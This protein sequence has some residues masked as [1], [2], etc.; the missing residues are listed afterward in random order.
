MLDLRETF[1]G[2]MGAFCCVY[3]GL[4]FEM[5][6]VRLQTQGS[7]NAYKSVI[8]AFRRIV[9]EE[10]VVALWKGAIPALSSSIIENSVLFSANGFAK[11]AAM[12]MYAKQYVEHEKE[13][14]LT[15][16]DEG[17]MGAFGGC[18]SATVLIR[19]FECLLLLL[20]V[21]QLLSHC[22]L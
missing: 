16:M 3:A 12:S 4:P 15:T 22:Q 10:G 7:R 17:C 20:L 18:F 11:R 9:T 19:T 14:Q 2:V 6:K 5:I 8:D 1:S 21:L 13:Y